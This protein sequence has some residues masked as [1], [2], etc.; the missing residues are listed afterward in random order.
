MV[1]ISRAVAV[2][3][4]RA[5]MVLPDAQRVAGETGVFVAGVGLFVAAVAEAARTGFLLAAV[6]VV[7]WVFWVFWVFATG[8]AADFATSAAPTGAL[9]QTTPANASE[10]IQNSGFLVKSIVNKCTR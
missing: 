3:R 9:V 6:F 10:P 4:A 1:A 8:V 7:V 5:D 2:A